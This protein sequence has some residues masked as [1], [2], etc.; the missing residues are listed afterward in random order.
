MRMNDLRQQVIREISSLRD[1]RRTSWVYLVHLGMIFSVFIGVLEG[2]DGDP[3]LQAALLLGLATIAMAICWIWARRLSKLQIEVVDYVK[4]TTTSRMMLWFWVI[5][6]SSSF[7]AEALGVGSKSFTPLWESS[8]LTFGGVG[9][10]LLTV[11][12]AYKE[13]REARASRRLR[14]RYA[15]ARDAPVPRLTETGDSKGTVTHCWMVGW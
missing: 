15:S 11:G 2:P 8:L 10:I 14:I 6:A 1:D 5:F 3:K 12:P 9:S 7:G 13:Y 4:G